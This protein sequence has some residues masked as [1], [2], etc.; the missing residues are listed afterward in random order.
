M[1][2]APKHTSSI[3]FRIAEAERC[4]DN[5]IDKSE[6]DN[7]AIDYRSLQITQS[8]FR[9]HLAHK[10]EALGWTVDYNSCYTLLLSVRL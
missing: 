6:T 9:T 4:I 7:I 1:A 8:D 2:R 5:L 3:Q 10:Y